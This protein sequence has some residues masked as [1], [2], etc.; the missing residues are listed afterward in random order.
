MY[1]DAAARR[2]K[3]AKRKRYLKKFREGQR[4]CDELFRERESAEQNCNKW[5]KQNFTCKKSCFINSFGDRKAGE[6]MRSK[7]LTSIL[8]YTAVVL[9][10]AVICA[11][12]EYG[13]MVY[14]A[15]R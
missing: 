9:I 8:T 4:E 14:I 2:K 5:D 7:K 15:G 12:L 10:G 1:R 3:R 13:A 11:L 6:D